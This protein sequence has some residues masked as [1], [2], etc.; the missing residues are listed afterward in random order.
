MAKTDYKATALKAAVLGVLLYILTP[1]PDDLIT[2]PILSFIF[3]LPLLV[4]IFLY[5]GVALILVILIKNIF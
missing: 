3:R 5:Y 4:T 2:I 1:T